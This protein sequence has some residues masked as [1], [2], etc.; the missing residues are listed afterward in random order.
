MP[1]EIRISEID[2]INLTLSPKTIVKATTIAC[3]TVLVL[4]VG[5]ELLKPQIKK[6]ND[7]LKTEIDKWSLP[8]E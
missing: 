3:A 4:K 8:A 7:A 6:F 1:E 5:V 2:N